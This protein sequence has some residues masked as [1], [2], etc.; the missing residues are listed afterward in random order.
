MTK[1]LVALEIEGPP[2]LAEAE[3][4]RAVYGMINRGGGWDYSAL[5]ATAQRVEAGDE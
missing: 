1:Y 2:S 5:S 3:V 4:A